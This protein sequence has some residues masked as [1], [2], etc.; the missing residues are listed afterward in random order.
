MPKILET[1]F[2][3]GGQEEAEYAAN[4]W[5]FTADPWSD[6]LLYESDPR[7]IQRKAEETYSLEEVYQNWPMGED[8]KEHARKMQDFL[9]QGA[10]RIFIPPA[11]RTSKGSS[12]SAAQRCCRCYAP[13]SSP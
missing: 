9:D 13:G 6:E 1:F 7:E 4:L 3:V 11:S 5:C 12:T 8:P 10:T 2:I